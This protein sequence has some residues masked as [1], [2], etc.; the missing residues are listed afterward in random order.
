MFLWPY[1]YKSPK[2][3]DLAEKISVLDIILMIFSAIFINFSAINSRIYYKFSMPLS[4]LF[5]RSVQ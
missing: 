5:N 3:A 2:T 4:A 1:V